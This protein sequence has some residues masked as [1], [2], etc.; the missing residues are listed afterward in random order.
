[1][2]TGNDKNQSPIIAHRLPEFVQTDHPT[3]V[4]FIQAYYEWL[5]QQADQGYVRTPAALDGLAD[6]DK[7]IEEFVGAFKKEYLTG[8]PEEFAVNADGNTVDARQLIKNIKEFYRNKGTEKTYEF[9]FRVLYDTAVEFYYPSRDILRLSDGKWIQKY[10]IRCSNDIGSKIFEARGKTVVQRTT[11]GSVIASGR[12]I[13]VSTYQ[14][15]SR[16]VAEMFISNING[17]FQSNTDAST[18]FGGIEFT[19][20]SGVLQQETRVYPILST[21]SISSQGLNYRKGDRIFFQPSIT[22]YKQNLLRS[23]NAI[24]N[25][26]YWINQVND[27]HVLRQKEYLPWASELINCLL[28]ENI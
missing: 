13:D 17:R 1:M 9:L 22:P 10:S 14:I 15:G 28:V 3:M 23:S 6:V 26:S 8:F 20:N 16:R 4:A 5:D 27:L 7:T 11:D 24:A 12:V 18:N 19:D 2:T 21:V 25:T